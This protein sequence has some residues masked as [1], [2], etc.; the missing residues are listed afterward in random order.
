MSR[1]VLQRIVP[2]LAVAAFLLAAL[3]PRAQALEVRESFG[4]WE[5]QW[6]TPV[7]TDQELCA[8]VQYVVAFDRPDVELRVTILKALGGDAHIL[9]VAAPLGVFLEPGL[10]LKIDE[11]ELGSVNF[12]R[13]LPS[14]CYVEL[15]MYDELVTALRE[16]ET[17]L[18]IVFQTPEEGIGIPISL[19]GFSEGFDA[20][21]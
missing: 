9:R 17:A 18:F 14:G 12:V 20:L 2:A 3:A 21:E 15:V 13:C 8:L 7:G 1:L 4:A 5:I 19:E 16:G 6:D 11:R 10:G